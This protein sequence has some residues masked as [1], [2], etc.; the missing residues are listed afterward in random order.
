MTHCE[1]VPYE[2][3]AMLTARRT[4]DSGSGPDEDP[5]VFF[6]LDLAGRAGITL[7]DV[8]ISRD[9]TLPRAQAEGALGL[10]DLATARLAVAVVRSGGDS[11]YIGVDG[12]ALVPEVQ[13]A[14]ARAAWR[15]LGLG[16]GA[17]VIDDPWVASSNEAWTLR[18]ISPSFGEAMGWIDSSDLGGWVGWSSVG[19]HITAR[20]DLTSGEGARFRERNEGKDVAGTVS[21]HPSAHASATAYVRDGSRGLGLARDHR[22]GMRASGEVGPLLLGV[23]G[24]AAWGVDG[25][26]TRQPLGTS[27]WVVVRAPALGV[28]WLGFGR[29]D[30]ATEALGES[31]AGTRT[32][33]AGAGMEVHA[34]NAK[35]DEPAPLRVVVGYTGTRVGDAVAGIAGAGALEDADTVYVQLGVTLGR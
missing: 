26:A 16:I 19:R 10:G 25:D 29:L 3:P 28:V 1:P 23:E 34:R 2:A 22:A 12:E 30:L 4:D 31:D 9:L 5:C 7:P 21:V 13:I 35:V 33:L 27:G 6:Q 17:G 14:E 20:V 32:L 8:G 24:L 15:P 18:A 11:G